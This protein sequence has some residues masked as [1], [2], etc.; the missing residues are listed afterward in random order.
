[1]L[2]TCYEIIHFYYFIICDLV[3]GEILDQ[4]NSVG[5]SIMNTL[6]T[7]YRFISARI[8]RWM[9]YDPAELP[10]IPGEKYC[11]QALLNTISKFPKENSGF[12]Q[13]YHQNSAYPCVPYV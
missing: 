7:L 10:I 11:A 5:N 9:T 13:I 6:N 2:T 1:M 4:R 8:S 3:S 12:C